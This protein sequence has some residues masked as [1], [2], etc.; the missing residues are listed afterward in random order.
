MIVSSVID[1]KFNGVETL[2][3]SQPDYKQDRQ[4]TYDVILRRVRVTIV[5]LKNQKYCIFLVCVCSL[6][7]PACEVRKL[8]YIIICSLS[9][10]T[11]VYHIIS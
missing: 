7:Y 1:I 2:S 11:V 10:S 9:C 8:N 5:T 6:S 4:Y 3:F